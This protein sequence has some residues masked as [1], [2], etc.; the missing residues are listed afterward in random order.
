MVSRRRR[1]RRYLRWRR[2]QAR[3]DRLVRHQD[4]LMSVC[5]PMRCNQGFF[6]AEGWDT[7][8]E[9]REALG[10]GA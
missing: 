3:I 2:Y 8:G 10:H 5:A 7:R 1:E 6:R 4:I 9:H